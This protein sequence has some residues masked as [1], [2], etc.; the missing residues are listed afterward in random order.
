MKSTILWRI[1]EAMTQEEIR[2][3]LKLYLE[4]NPVT[5]STLARH[6]GIHYQTLSDFLNGR[7]RVYQ[8]VWQLLQDFV[9]TR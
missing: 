1:G 7:R 5:V 8:R 4:S 2:A 9:M 3:K 6:L